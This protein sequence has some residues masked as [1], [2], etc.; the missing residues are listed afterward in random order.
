[1]FPLWLFVVLPINYEN[2]RKFFFVFHQVQRV[3]PG[4]SNL[5]GTSLLGL[6]FSS[7]CDTL[8]FACKVTYLCFLL[9][10]IIKDNF[11]AFSCLFVL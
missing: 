3:L 9:A 11:I 7:Y 6:T 10:A 4:V 5:L 8:Y 1:M 2:F